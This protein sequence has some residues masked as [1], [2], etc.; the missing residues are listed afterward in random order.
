MVIVEVE[1]PLC[2]WSD[3]IPHQDLHVTIPFKCIIGFLKVK[4][5]LIEDILPH[6][7]HL[8]DHIDFK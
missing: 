1:K 7:R 5:D 3:F 8:L 6:R 2:P 4:E